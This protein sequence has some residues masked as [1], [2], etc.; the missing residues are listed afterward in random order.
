MVSNEIKLSMNGKG[1][2][3]DNVFIEHLWRSVNFESISLNPPGSGIDTYKQ[4]RA[5]FQ[6]Y[7]QREDIKESKIK[8]ML[9][10]I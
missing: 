1:R 2:A 3:I 7:N 6:L 4:C 5:Y 10:G 9:A 8:Y